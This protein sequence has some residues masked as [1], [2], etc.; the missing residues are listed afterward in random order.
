[1]AKHGNDEQ[2]PDSVYPVVVR[3]N[4]GVYPV[5]ARVRRGIQEPRAPIILRVFLDAATTRS[6]T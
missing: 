4:G 5:I 3:A 6:M 1:M 2:K